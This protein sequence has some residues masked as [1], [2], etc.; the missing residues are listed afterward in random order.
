MTRSVDVMRGPR[1][2]VKVLTAEDSAERG[3]RARAKKFVAAHRGPLTACYEE[4]FGRDPIFGLQ[5][6]VGLTLV[7]SKVDAATLRKGALIDAAG[8]RCL[9]EALVAA[10]AYPGGGA[11]GRATVRL[12]FYFDE[13]KFIHPETG[14]GFGAAGPSKAAE[15]DRVEAQRFAR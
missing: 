12:L 2:V 9:L 5:L 13:T 10:K 14:E 8:N 7:G 1:A 11:L 15:P 6:E 3:A 4:A